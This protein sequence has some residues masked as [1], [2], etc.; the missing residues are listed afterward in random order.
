M[1]SVPEVGH[2]EED[3]VNGEGAVRAA[4]ANVVAVKSDWAEGAGGGT[5][6]NLKYNLNTLLNPDL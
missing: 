6:H 4:V 1:T 5:E 3:V 2:G